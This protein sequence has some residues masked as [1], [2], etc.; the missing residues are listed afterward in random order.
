[1][2]LR[3]GR[4]PPRWA[5]EGIA[6]L[7][8]REEKQALHLRDCQHA[9]RGGTA[10]RLAEVARLERFTS[11]DEVAAFYGQSLSLVR[12]LVRQGSPGQFVD[13]VRAAMNQGYDKALRQNYQ[14]DSLVQLERQ[15][16]QAVMPATETPNPAVPLRLVA[17][18]RT[19]DQAPFEK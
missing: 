17:V 9:L 3:C 18:R 11:D 14:I 8:D 16:R 19:G 13:F 1:L 12:Y 4:Q 10:L 5:D 7:S 6:L 15:W 2:P